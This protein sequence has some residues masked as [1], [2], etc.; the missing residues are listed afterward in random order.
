MR[1][2]VTTTSLEMTD[3]A[4]HRAARPAT[5]PFD[6]VRA[7]LACPEL[8]RF[9]YA[10]VGAR[11]G[12]Y[13]RLPW[14]FARWLAYLDRPELETWIAYVTG[15]TAGYFELERQERGDV[16]LAYFGLLPAFIGQGMGGVLLTRAIDR[17]WDMGAR[18]VWVHTCTLDHPRALAN[19]L[20]RGFRIFRVEEKLEELPDHPLEPWPGAGADQHPAIAAASDV[21]QI[22][23]GDLASGTAAALIG[24]L[25]AELSTR[26]PEDGATHFR[27]DA[28]EVAE[29]RGVFLVA[30]RGADA[31]G[32]GAVR[33]IG[34]ALGELKRMYVVAGAR[35]H[36]V[37]RALLRA[38][39]DE[40]RRLG[41]SR[42]VLETGERQ[43]EALALYARAGYARI[44]AFGEYVASPLSVC[45]GKD[46]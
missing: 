34:N 36:G 16:E 29:G 13:S 45:M 14:D 19:Y 25:N 21:V 41:L 44:P 32:C 17:A 37:G 1:A 39:E 46:L 2:S 11:W 5:R 38:L 12:W 18:R 43:G 8:N 22:E 28:D 26:Y 6:L 10:A 31:V 7:E 20:A 15:T 27:L 35:R 3:R 33:R 9:L 4:E 40:A 23:R 24:G 30:Y 42:L